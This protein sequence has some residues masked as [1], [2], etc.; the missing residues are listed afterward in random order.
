MLRKTPNSGQGSGLGAVLI[1]RTKI[2]LTFLKSITSSMCVLNGKVKRSLKLLYC[3]LEVIP[4][5]KKS[6]LVD[7]FPK[8]KKNEKEN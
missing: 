7:G 4:W 3:H 5:D 1:F 6:T 2:T 8:K